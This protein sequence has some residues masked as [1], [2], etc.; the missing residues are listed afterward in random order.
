MLIA[1]EIMEAAPTITAGATIRNA[2]ASVRDSHSDQLYLTDSLG[3]LQGV[4][5][6]YALLKALLRGENDEQ[7]IES[8]TA[9]LADILTPEQPLEQAAL[10]FRCGY[11]TQM[12]V[13]D[14]GRL[15]GIVRRRPLLL[16]ISERREYESPA[17]APSVLHS[18]G[19]DP[20]R[21]T[22]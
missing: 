6:D 8:L 9:P 20:L 21:Q 17:E 3:R 1:R 18:L 10:F 2:V 16:A 19:R 12:A 7:T 14:E 13:V 5:T 22:G 4:V 11:R 15:L